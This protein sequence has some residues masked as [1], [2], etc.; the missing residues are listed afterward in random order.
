[1]REDVRIKDIQTDV[2]P[3][4]R[5]VAVDLELTPFIERPTIELYLENENGEKAG[6]ITI[7]ETMDFRVGVVV[8]LRDKTPT[9]NYTITATVY[10]AALEKGERQVVHRF[11][12]TFA[13]A[14]DAEP[15]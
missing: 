1:M 11:Q 14:P 5:R 9:A 2:A 4:G 6:A 12:K 10:Y 7:I 15:D 3:D 8:H 13:I